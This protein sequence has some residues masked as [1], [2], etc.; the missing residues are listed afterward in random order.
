[1]PRDVSHTEL[2]KYRRLM[3]QAVEHTPTPE[4]GV[5]HDAPAKTKLVIG[6]IRGGKSWV[7]EKEMLS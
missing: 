4:Q 1:M 3:F 7:A 2:M 6:G 5:V